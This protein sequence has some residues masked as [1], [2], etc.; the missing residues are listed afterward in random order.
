MYVYVTV[1]FERSY[2]FERE[3]TREHVGGVGERGEKGK[4]M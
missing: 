1:F 3:R 2:G 4:M